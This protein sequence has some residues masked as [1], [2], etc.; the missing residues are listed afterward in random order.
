MKT[1]EAFNKV[2]KFLFRW[3]NRD[4]LTFL[5]FFFIAGVFWLLTTLNETYEKEFAVPVRYT[6]VPRDVVL[7]SNE[8]DTVKVT[9]R[10][11]G[12]SLVTYFYGK[13]KMP[14][15]IDFNRYKRTDGRGIVE[16]AD[17]LP[18]IDKALPAS[19]TALSI[20]PERLTFYYNH[21]EQKLVPVVY[22]GKVEPDP[23]YY[24]SQVNY[25]QE[26]IV[27]YA[28]REKLDSIENVYTMPIKATGFRDSL[29]VSCN[30]QPMEGVKMVPSNIQVTFC[31]DIL[32]E[33]SIE[34]VKVV[35]I[36][37]PAGKTMRTFPAKVKVLFVSGM[38]NYQALSA[39]DFLVV[40]DYNEV[41]NSP[42]TK[43]NL[44]LRGNPIGVSRVT[45]EPSQVEYLLE[46]INP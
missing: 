38:K 5:F 27:V 13:D 46:D 17:L 19:A 7:T 15:L 9:V 39:E 23:I 6:N 37:I 32:T 22:Q 26:E 8:N 31:T 24:I 35:G 41:A 4:F 10:D 42:S 28:P 34:G 40:A 29:T 11:K 1:R 16:A 12:I 14:I 30:L 43:C 33:A 21:G 20:K 36:N 18:L 3:V 44:Y 2:S 25:S 45:I